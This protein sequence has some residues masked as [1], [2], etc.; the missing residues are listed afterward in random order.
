[1]RHGEGEWEQSEHG[2]LAHQV[3]AELAHEGRG[4]EESG[5]EAGVHG[6][7]DWE[8]EDSAKPEIE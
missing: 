3:R 6:G 4:H 7:P 5:Q 1:M 8:D 2:S